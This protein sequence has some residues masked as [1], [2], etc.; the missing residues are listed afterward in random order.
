MM[1]Y[2]DMPVYRSPHDVNVSPMFYLGTLTPSDSY[3]KR[4]PDAEITR[5]H[6]LLINNVKGM[7]YYAPDFWIGTTWNEAYSA[8]YYVICN[9]LLEHIRVTEPDSERDMH[10]MWLS[11]RDTFAS[12]LDTDVRNTA[13]TNMLSYVT[14]NNPPV[15]ADMTFSP[16]RPVKKASTTPS[17]SYTTLFEIKWTLI[18]TLIFFISYIGACSYGVTTSIGVALSPMLFVGAAIDIYRAIR[19]IKKTL[20]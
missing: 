10:L 5:E 19:D 1:R 3:F 20:D 17:R 12:S 11:E 8:G 16:N 13:F 15:A 6:I 14:E 18:T 2:E 7:H 9:L 4:F